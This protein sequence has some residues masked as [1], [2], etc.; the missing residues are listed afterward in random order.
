MECENEGLRKWFFILVTQQLFQHSKRAGV[1]GR[2]PGEKGN[3]R[4]DIVQMVKVSYSLYEY[5]SHGVRRTGLT[6]FAI[7]PQPVMTWIVCTPQ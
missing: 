1:E 2:S 3:H 7:Q 4:H 5:L 6:M